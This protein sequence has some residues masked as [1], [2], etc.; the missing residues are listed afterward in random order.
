MGCVLG[1]HI[2]WLADFLDDVTRLVAGDPNW[3]H[4]FYVKKGL[5]IPVE[6]TTIKVCRLDKI[7]KDLYFL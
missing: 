2:K 4:V 7:D 3:F 5:N 1:D 6:N